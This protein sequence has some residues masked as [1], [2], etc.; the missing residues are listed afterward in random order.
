MAVT[1]WHSHLDLL[2]NELRNALV[3]SLASAPSGVAGRIYYDSVTGNLRWYDG[4]ATTWQ[5]A[6]GEGSS[7]TDEEA[8]D[9]IGAALTEGANIQITVDD[10]S[11]TI[12]IAVV[13]LD[14][15]DISDFDT[16]VRTSRLDQM[17]APTA[18][19]DLNGQKIVDLADGTDPTDAAT[20][21]QLQSV[22]QGQFWK[23][24]VRAATTADITLSGTQTIDGVDVVADDRVL[25]KNQTSTEDNGI[26][27]VAEGAWT[28]AADA[29]A[30]AEVNNATV[31]IEEGTVNQ[32]DI[33][34]QTAT[35]STLG[36]DAQTWTKIAEGNTV[37]TAGDGLDL[38]GSAFSVDA[39]VGRIYQ[40]TWTGASASK[41]VTHNLGR[42]FVHVTVYDES[43]VEIFGVEVTATSTTQ[44]DLAVN[45]APDSA[46]WTIVVVG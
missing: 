8:R 17:A 22:L 13:G 35:V 12:T 46:T 36:T 23:D 9:A 43:D 15:G 42:Q 27:V 28:R 20:F 24:P 19:V 29:N 25:V 30:A 44:C 7:Y 41:T 14:S 33:Y 34:S 31:L 3:Q 21:G 11:D 16:Q 6:G 26:Y 1:T 38:T 45:V 39:T 40:D 10:E 32:G 5:D 37:Y 2:T 4:V 18:D